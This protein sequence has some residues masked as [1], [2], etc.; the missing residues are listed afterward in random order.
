VVGAERIRGLCSER[1]AAPATLCRIVRSCR[2]RGIVVAPPARLQR[3]P[4][5]SSGREGSRGVVS[6]Q[7]GAALSI[8]EVEQV[9]PPH[10]QP[11]TD[12]EAAGGVH[13]ASRSSAIAKPI[14]LHDLSDREQV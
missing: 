5:G 11:G 4:G 12:P 3:A 6:G 9:A 2:P 14:A 1:K 8:L 7:A 13:H 10:E